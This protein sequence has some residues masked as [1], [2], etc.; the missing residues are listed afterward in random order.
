[1][2]VWR[3]IGEIK[4]KE[5]LSKRSQIVIINDVVSAIYL[6]TKTK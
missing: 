5:H 3:V 6:F 2:N 1:M 4:H